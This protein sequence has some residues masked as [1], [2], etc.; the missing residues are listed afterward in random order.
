MARDNVNQRVLFDGKI[1]TVRTRDALLAAERLWQQRGRHHKRIRLAQGSFSTSVAASGNTHAGDAVVDIRTTGVGLTA[2]ETVAL[3]RALR[4]V[5]FAAWIRDARDGMPPHI[6][7]ACIADPEMDP[8][9]ARQVIDY[10]KGLN[11]LSN[12]AKDRNSYRPKPKVRFSWLQG[13]PVP[14]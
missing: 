1:V 9:A 5:G 8:S 14:R 3:L 6:H 7:A 12:K 13:K 4:D 10:D 2:G 11:G